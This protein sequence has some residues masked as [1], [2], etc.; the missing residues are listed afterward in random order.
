MNPQRRRWLL[1]CAAN[2]AGEWAA[3]SAAGSRVTAIAAGG[4]AASLKASRAVAISASGAW[5][6]SSLAAAPTPHVAG[7]D[8]VRL[9]R[10]LQ[11]PRDHG[12][13]PAQRTEWWYATGWLGTPTAPSHGWQVTFFR[14]ATGLGA[15]SRSRFA[16]RHVLFAHAAITDLA[17]QQHLHAQRMARWSGAPDAAPDHAALDRGALRLAAWS[18]ADDGAAWQVQVAA[19]GFDLKLELRRT[20]PVLLQGEAGYSRKGPPD[21]SAPSAHASHYYSEPQ[22]ATLAHLTLGEQGTGQTPNVA[23]A[24]APALQG[25]AWLDHEWSDSLLPPQAV[26]WDWIGMNL[27][28]GS[29]LTAFQLRRADGS[30]LWAGGSWRAGAGAVPI[31]AGAG[32]AGRAGVAG[33]DGGAGAAQS[34]ASQAV[35]FQPGTRWRSGASGANYAIQWTVSTPVGRFEVRALMPA[36]ELDSR[37]GTGAFY[38]EGLSELLDTTGRRVGLG[39]LEMTGY[40]GRLRMGASAEP[41][42]AMGKRPE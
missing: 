21:A 41:G 25:R 33:A 2:A 26:G 8:R 7:T 27:F 24:T 39:Y 42:T 35:S 18:L 4:R 14:S 32:V 20:Q 3:A 5:A 16:P 17:A 13:H 40:A 10:V 23:T 6:A 12:A 9:D 15:G 11:F 19:E 1:Q 31:G 29:A 34:F 28:D 38:W 37:T 22:L 36:Q 30:T